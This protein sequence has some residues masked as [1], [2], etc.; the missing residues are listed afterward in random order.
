MAATRKFGQLC[1][2]LFL[3][4]LDWKL[5]RLYHCC[6]VAVDYCVRGLMVGERVEGLTLDVCLGLELLCYIAH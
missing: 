4:R 6:A 1:E 3:F 2:F 5:W